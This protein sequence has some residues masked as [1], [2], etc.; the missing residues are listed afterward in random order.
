MKL[1]IQIPCFNEAETLPQ[2][3][4]ALPREVQGFDQV[5]WLVIDDGSTDGTT[6]VAHAQ[7]VDHV[8]RLDHNSGL[9]KAFMTGLE[10]SLKRG[11]DVIV[12]TDADN[13]YRADAIP[14]L[15]KPV[16]E[17][18]A[19]IVIGSRPIPQIAHFSFWKRVLQK[20]GSKV[21]RLAAGIE[22]PDAPSGFRAFHRE[23]AMQLYVFNRYTYTLETIIQAGRLNIPLVWVP[24]EVNAPTRPSR[25]VRNSTDYIF[26]SALT[27]LRIFI[28]YRPFRFFALCA[29]L[30]SFPGLVAY[31]RFLI[32]WLMG[33]GSGKIQ[34]LIIGGGFIVSGMILFIGGI[35]ADMIA[36]NRMLLAEIRFRQLRRDLEL[37]K[38]KGT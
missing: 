34:S 25:L 21:V 20:T 24:V 9:A 2:T 13:Q 31:T 4:A 26:K 10:E 5:E 15:T 36:A 22:V 16:V 7:G 8:V 38:P 17:G 28:L 6:D 11:A 29:F 14:A 35:L 3:L 32:F 30:V 12:N 27:I 19:H 1:I 37:K 33:E 23:A 18:H